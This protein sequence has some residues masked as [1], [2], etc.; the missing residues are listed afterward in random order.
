M[1]FS[2]FGAKLFSDCPEVSAKIANKEYKLKDM[3]E[4]VEEY[5]L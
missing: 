3:Y 2:K 5:N 4:I 1:R